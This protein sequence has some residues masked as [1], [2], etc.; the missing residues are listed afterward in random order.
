MAKAGDQ[1][2][3]KASGG[4]SVLAVLIVSVITA[5]A[6]AG[7]GVLAPGLFKPK[8][9]AS[10]EQARAEGGH[11]PLTGTKLVVLPPITTNIAKPTST[12]IRLETIIVIDK[13]LGPDIGVVLGKMSADIVGYL[14]TVS[15]DEIEGPSGFQHL[16]EDLSDRVRVRSEGKVSELVITSMI[17]E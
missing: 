16:L 7:F 8:E 1:Q 4:I 9:Q 10:H 6:G 12:W 13:D 11:N 2:E 15:L 3:V 14:R 17:I 5:G